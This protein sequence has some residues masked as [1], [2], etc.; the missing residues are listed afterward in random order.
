VK[1]PLNR[2]S[3]LLFGFVFVLIATVLVSAIAVTVLWAKPNNPNKPNKP[4]KPEEPL[5]DFVEADFKI[6]I[7][8][9]G[10]GSPED[11]VLRP[12][13]D[14]EMNYL[15]V[16]DYVDYYSDFWISTNS[17]APTGD[18]HITLGRVNDGDTAAPYCGTYDIND[19]SLLDA[20]NL[21]GD[22]DIDNQDVYMLA[23]QHSTKALLAD[24]DRKPSDVDYWWIQLVWATES[25]VEVPNPGGEPD[26]M[27][28]PHMY[29]LD[30]KTNI[31]LEPEGV[32][33]EVN[34]AW[35]IT[36]DTV[37]ELLENNNEPSNKFWEGPLSFTVEIQKI[38]P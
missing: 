15:F 37:F 8:D 2:R 7:G 16:Q 30:G 4:E 1:K 19:Q 9:G 11:V 24:D 20:L 21:Q 33:D 6:W 35:T 29:I 27:I 14:P 13:G 38:L 22:F 32:Y 28:F 26:P 3:T 36:F 23:I 12:Y 25:T 18:W 34:G 10:L 5:P 31:N 17:K